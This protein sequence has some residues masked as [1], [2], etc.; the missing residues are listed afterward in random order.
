MVRPV[1][2]APYGDVVVGPVFLIVA[3]V[4]GQGGQP[5]TCWRQRCGAIAVVK[6]Q[7]QNRYCAHF[8]CGLQCLG[9]DDK[10]VE[11]AEAFTVVGMSVMEPAG[12]L[13]V[14]PIT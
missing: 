12:K 7:I 1:G 5:G 3:A 14:D 13:G 4:D 8:A 10:T 11:R 2:V 6:V 9:S